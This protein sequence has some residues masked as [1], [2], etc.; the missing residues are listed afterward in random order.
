MV[1]DTSLVTYVT[2]IFVL[3]GLVK[4]IIGFGLP[5]LSLALLVL[6]VDIEAA[7]AILIIP[8]LITNVWQAF[9]GGKL[10][11]LSLRI[12]PFLL[13]AFIGVQFGPLVLSANVIFRVCS[14]ALRITQSI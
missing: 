3:A 11:T 9:D 2:L 5:T 14:F 7:M 4:G 1:V 8:S 10:T 6:I 13:M 12:W